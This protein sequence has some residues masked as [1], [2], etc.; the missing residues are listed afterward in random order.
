MAL[1]KTAETLRGLGGALGCS[2]PSDPR[3]VTPPPAGAEE[4]VIYVCVCVC[5]LQS[6]SQAQAESALMLMMSLSH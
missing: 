4:G 3:K 2:C 6:H 5:H 1:G